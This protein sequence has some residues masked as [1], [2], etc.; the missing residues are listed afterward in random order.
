MK[1]RIIYLLMTALFIITTISQTVV[2]IYAQNQTAT[3]SSHLSKVVD[4]QKAIE[5]TS[6]VNSV[7]T[8]SNKE[9]AL[10]E[11]QKAAA[12]KSKKSAKSTNLTKADAIQAGDIDDGIPASSWRIGA[13]AAMG[14][15][16]FPQKPTEGVDYIFGSMIQ[17]QYPTDET[18]SGIKI[19]SDMDYSYINKGQMNIAITHKAGSRKPEDL[20]GLLLGS[21]AN[22]LDTASGPQTSL[23]YGLVFDK[24]DTGS[25]GRNTGMQIGQ[26]SILANKLKDKVYYVEDTKSSAAAVKVMGHFTRTDPKDSTKTHQY[27]VEILM[28]P[29]SGV[30]PAVQQELYI[31]NTSGKADSYGVLFSQ[32]TSL[33]NGLATEDKVPIKSIGDDQGLYIEEPASNAKMLAKMSVPDGPDDFGTPP[34]TEIAPGTNVFFPYSGKTFMGD[35]QK[36]RGLTK[37]PNTILMQ[38]ANTSY[39]AKWDFNTIQ[40]DETKHYRQDIVGVTGPL[41][42]P[43]TAKIWKN[44]TSKDNLN[45]VGDT[46]QYTLSVANSGY[47]DSWQGIK[48]VDTGISEHLKVDDQSI[49]V[50]VKQFSSTGKETDYVA[51]VPASAYDETA[52][53]LTV[54][55]GK[56]KTTDGKSVPADLNDNDIAEI[57]FNAKIKNSGSNQTIKNHFET[58]GTD[59]DNKAAVIKDSADNEFKVEQVEDP[60]SMTKLVRNVSKDSQS[61]FA[62]TTDAG[63][64]DHVQYQIE[65]T[66]SP[67]TDLTGGK[68]KDKLDANLSVTKT[69]VQYQQS[70]DSW[71]T[72]TDATWDKDN[73]LALSTVLTGKKVRIIIDATVGDKVTDGQVINNTAELVAGSYGIGTTPEADAKITIIDKNAIAKDSMHQYIKNLTQKDTSDT[74]DETTGYAG[75]KIQY[76][77][78]GKSDAGNTKKLLKLA[79]ANIKMAPADEM[80]YVADSLK[81][82]GTAASAAIQQAFKDGKYTKID[83]LDELAKDTALTVTYE[84]TVKSN[85]DQTITNDGWLTA[86]KLDGSVAIDAAKPDVK[87]LKFNTT[88]LTVKKL[89]LT[90]TKKVG[91]Y[92]ENVAPTTFADSVEARPGNKVQYQIDITPDTQKVLSGITVEDVLDAD[93]SS[94]NNV[95]KVQRQKADGSWGNADSIAIDASGQIKIPD[96]NTDAYKGWKMLRITID[97]TIKDAVKPATKT[98]INNQATLVAGSYGL[99][100]KTNVATIT[101]LDKLEATVAHTVNNL[102][103]GTGAAQ[104]TFASR[105]DTVEYSYIVDVTGSNSADLKKLAIKNIKINQTGI[106]KFVDGSLKIS[107]NGSNNSASDNAIQEANL[108]NNAQIDLDDAAA[109]KAQYIVQYQMQIVGT[110]YRSIAN[111]ADLTATKLD[112]ATD[113]VKAPNSYRVPTTTIMPMDKPQAVVKQEVTNTTR[114]ESDNTDKTETAA[115]VGDKLHY[116]FSVTTKGKLTNTSIKDIIQ[117]PSQLMDYD[118]NS[119]KVTIQ[120]AGGS[121]IDLTP[122][123]SG[124]PGNGLVKVGDL[125]AK[126][127]LTVSY[128]RTL[129]DYNVSQSNVILNAG[130][131][132]ADRLASTD[133]NAPIEDAEKNQIPF[134]TTKVNI[135]TEQNVSVYSNIKNETKPDKDW[136]TKTDGSKD[137]VIGYRFILNANSKNNA[138]VKQIKLTDI[139]LDP[140]KDSKNG[141]MLTYIPNSFRVVVNGAEDTGATLSADHKTVTLGK[142][143]KKGQVAIVLYQMKVNTEDVDIPIK[144]HATLSAERLTDKYGD[145]LKDTTGTATTE[146]PV[147]DTTLNLKLGKSQT[148]I[149]YVDMD[150]VTSGLS[151]QEWLAPAEAA[152][153]KIGEPF[154]KGIYTGGSKDGTTVGDA[155]VAPK[156]IDGYTIIAVSESTD[157]ANNPAWAKA[158]KDDPLFTKDGRTITYGYRKR[159]ISIEAPTYWDFG[160]RNRSQTDSTYYLEDLKEPQKVQVTDNYGVQSWQLQVAQKAPFTDDR[161]Q[162]LKDAE[163]QFRNGT[164][165]ADP[166]N[167]TPTQAISTVDQFNL[168]SGDTVKN[169]MTYKKSGVFQDADADQDKSSETNPYSDDQGKGTWTYTFGN[170]QNAGISIGLYVPY[171]TKRDNTTYTTTLDWSLTVAP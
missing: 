49:K 167:T 28:R 55:L 168:K 119:L 61:A 20:T 23:G 110:T 1:K 83:A 146:M 117:T 73:Q 114:P 104:V 140:D 128:D 51:N 160:E 86:T 90:M 17:P 158:Y 166:N 53:T 88:S 14:F 44:T 45:H 67:N 80:T 105:G 115:K 159:M 9:Q 138:D 103:D 116:T 133:P 98:K 112:N 120:A 118:A 48:V 54:E 12:E 91:L 7:L 132:L 56:L 78:T 63:S 121:P 15:K 38:K 29:A 46:G 87:G 41:V 170:K 72:L 77:F 59:R 50:T 24:N 82:N 99:G 75:D 6:S 125:A 144:N 129:T 157:L 154:S 171:T 97:A 139:T 64:G 58:T 40:P 136:A 142:P 126:Q 57:T 62:A 65:T 143:L 52:K 11:S 37:S 141:D 137:D 32:D 131:L 164:L 35:A 25:W 162:E 161:K 10:E 151:Q 111:N 27:L 155:R 92:K 94:T 70:D 71:S 76:T 81:I 89:N 101:L 43:S 47:L 5:S 169:L 148:T 13:A 60:T 113:P 36:R 26:V 123:V 95:A 108:K 18:T 147:D 93:L 21:V 16:A 66:V 8:N 135:K 42:A 163:L 100:T 124:F 84:M 39:S 109:P 122:T 79:I 3:S 150:K 19:G 4:Y 74:L 127:V 31:K 156:V 96:N 145:K 130:T 85:K 165:S 134:N 68:I 106:M 69:Q 153:G 102:S 30:I 107:K 152:I 2:P 22:G 33:G 34:S 149:R